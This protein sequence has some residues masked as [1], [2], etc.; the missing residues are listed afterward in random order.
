MHKQLKGKIIFII[1]LYIMLII[2]NIGSKS[3]L[4]VLILALIEELGLISYIILTSRPII[5]L[6]II[7][8]Q[9][10]VYLVYDLVIGVSISEA[11]DRLMGYGGIALVCILIHFLII[12]KKGSKERLKSRIKKVIKTERRPYSIPIWSKIII[13]STLVIS[14]MS[15]SK[16]NNIID[17]LSLHG[18]FKVYAVI[19]MIMPY[20]LYFGIL[21]TTQLA[22][23]FWFIRI[24]LE[25]ITLINLKN[26]ES[27][28]VLQVIYV[29]LEI[30]IFIY[31]IKKLKVRID[32]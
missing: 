21:T 25:L 12:D 17:E 29:L 2:C 10:L 15:I 11:I 1:I 22:Y 19:V 28:E 7:L 30:L 3:I 27:L 31:T 9:Q 20:I 4:P 23:E 24:V 32:E 14:I 26:I 18:I 6:I 5:A 13:Y 8:T 16:S